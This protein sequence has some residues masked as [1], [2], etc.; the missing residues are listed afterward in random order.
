MCLFFVCH[1]TNHHPASFQSQ[2]KVH[3]F[4]FGN[5]NVK[6]KKLNKEINKTHHIL[7]K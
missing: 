7:S 4:K 2:W 1:T 6:L 5:V 3:I